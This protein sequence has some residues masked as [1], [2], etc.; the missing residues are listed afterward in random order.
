RNPEKRLDSALEIA[1]LLEAVVQDD[2]RFDGDRTLRASAVH[3]GID[4]DGDAPTIL[5][6]R[7]DELRRAV[8]SMGKAAPAAMASPLP[9]PSS[10][11]P[12]RPPRAAPF[13]TGLA[14]GA[15]VA[16]LAALAL[17]SSP[18]DA[19]QVPLARAGSRIWS[20]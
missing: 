2:S 1:V 8:A 6:Q 19:P 15:G 13:V 4:P 17:S 14:V 9:I 7:P 12:L 10:L 11:P 5:F 16:L 20:L 18:H 3:P